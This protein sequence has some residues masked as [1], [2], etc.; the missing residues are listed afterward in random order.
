LSVSPFFVVIVAAVKSA[1]P[2]HNY[3]I[4]KFNIKVKICFDFKLLTAL[5]G[6]VGLAP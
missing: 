3:N 6:G 5:K 4:Y 2:Y 1:L